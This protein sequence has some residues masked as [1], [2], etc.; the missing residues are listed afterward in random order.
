MVALNFVFLIPVAADNCI[1]QKKFVQKCTIHDDSVV[2][3]YGTLRYQKFII[4][5]C[6]IWPTNLNKICCIRKGKYFQKMPG[7]LK[8]KTNMYLLKG[9]FLYE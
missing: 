5:L 7:K 6:E 1:V 2:D 8:G 3:G 9:R 4:Q